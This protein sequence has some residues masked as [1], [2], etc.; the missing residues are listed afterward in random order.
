MRSE[1]KEIGRLAG[2]NSPV[3]I[4][5]GKHKRSKPYEK[6]ELISS[7]TCRRTAC[8]NMFK[9]R[10]PVKQIM[11]I[12]G[13]KKESTFYKYIKITAEENAIMLSEQFGVS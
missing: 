4:E 8:T 6:W 2:I 13:H 10:I 1:A 12:S 11:M 5:T 7:H 3:I 9:M